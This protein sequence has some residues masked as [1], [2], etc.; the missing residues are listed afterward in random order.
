MK[1][2]VSRN[3]KCRKKFS[4]KIVKLKDMF[5]IKMYFKVSFKY[6]GLNLNE[7]CVKTYEH[8]TLEHT[9]EEEI[10]FRDHLEEEYSVKCQEDFKII[11]LKVV[12]QQK[13][14]VPCF[15]KVPEYICILIIWNNK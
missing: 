12:S 9:P 15:S 7:L 10:L 13:P 11:S 8:F 1:G 2:I 14:R 6:E 3:E 5:V 4:C